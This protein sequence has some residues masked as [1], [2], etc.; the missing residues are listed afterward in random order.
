MF[1]APLKTLLVTALNNTF[2]STY[3]VPEWQGLYSS[4]EYPE[5]RVAYP[6]VWVDFDPEDALHTINVGETSIYNLVD[7]VWNEVKGYRYQGHA[8]FTVVALTSLERDRLFDELVKVF[9]FGLLQPQTSAFRQ[10]ITGN[11]FIA[12][13]IDFDSIAMR[14]SNQTPGTPWGSNEIIYEITLSLAMLGEFYS[15]PATNTL[16]TLR[17]VLVTPTPEPPPAVPPGL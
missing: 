13:N 2:D 14:G 11:E 7:D 15:N 5:K 3:P 10:T 8:L 16:Y 12:A 17:E 4:I 6:G 9:A 1:L